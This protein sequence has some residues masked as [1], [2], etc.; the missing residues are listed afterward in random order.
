MRQKKK[1]LET[2]NRNLETEKGNLETD[3]RSIWRE[4]KNLETE[5]RSVYASHSWKLTGGFRKGKTVLVG[6]LHHG[7]RR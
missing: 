6:L 3:N 1:N 4:K 7:D 2:K 5:L